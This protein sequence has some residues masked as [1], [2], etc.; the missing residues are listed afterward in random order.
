MSL[1]HRH[2]WQK[3]E[4]EYN[5]PL[6]KAERTVYRDTT[7]YQLQSH[8]FTN[9]TWKCMECPKVKIQQHVGKVSF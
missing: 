6:P 8:G 2:T 7:L 4:V 5:D 3:Y 9:I 1:F